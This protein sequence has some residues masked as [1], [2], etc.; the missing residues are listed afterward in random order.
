MF[1]FLTQNPLPLRDLRLTEPH[2]MSGIVPTIIR[3]SLL[4][5][6][7]EEDLRGF[8]RHFS[9]PSYVKMR[10]HGDGDLVFEPRVDPSC[11]ED[12]HA[13]GWTLMYIEYLNYGPRFPF[14]PF[15]NNLLISVNRA[16]DRLDL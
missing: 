9:I 4:V 1:L 2:N 12:P 8:K 11:S 10:L 7:S 15:I 5:P 6:F 16:L 14:S 3:D 13:P